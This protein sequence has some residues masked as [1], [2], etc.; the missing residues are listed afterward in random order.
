ML[1]VQEAALC[2]ADQ[3]QDFHLLE[4]RNFHGTPGPLHPL[5]PSL[6]ASGTSQ[7]D[8]LQLVLAPQEETPI[9]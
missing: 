9:R 1:D 2:R 5:G 3:G 4:Q 7:I 8:T 6:G